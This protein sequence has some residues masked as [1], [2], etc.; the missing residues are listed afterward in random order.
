MNKTITLSI[1]CRHCG[2]VF[3]ITMTEQQ[4]FDYHNGCY[5]Q[6][7][8]PDK[9]ANERELLI[10]GICGKCYDAMMSE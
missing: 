4:Y 6:E 1:K 7:V 9:S 5:V 3:N 2:K 10:S 8:F